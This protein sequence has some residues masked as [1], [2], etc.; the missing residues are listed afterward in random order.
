MLLVGADGSVSK[1]PPAS[2][3]AMELK[4]RQMDKIGLVLPNKKI[5]S[6]PTIL[7]KVGNLDVV[8]V[9]IPGKTIKGLSGCPFVCLKSMDIL[10]LY[11]ENIDVIGEDWHLAVPCGIN[12][13]VLNALVLLHD[14]YIAR[15]TVALFWAIKTKCSRAAPVPLSAVQ[16][17]ALP[18][19]LRNAFGGV[20]SN[21]ELSA[22]NDQLNLLQRKGSF[23]SVYHKE[24]PVPVVVGD[25]MSWRSKA[26]LLEEDAIIY[27]VFALAPPMVYRRVIL[28]TTL[29]V[30]RSDGS[31]SNIT[32]REIGHLRTRNEEEDIAVM[33]SH[34]RTGTSFPLSV[35][36]DGPLS[37]VRGIKVHGRPVAG[38]AGFP[39]TSR[40][41]T[42]LGTYTESIKRIGDVWY[43]IIPS[44]LTS[45]EKG[46]LL[47]DR[48]WE[49][50][51]THPMERAL[52]EDAAR[53]AKNLAIVD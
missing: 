37:G 42:F 5:V 1:L 18:A 9:K 14:K 30:L 6:L 8:G 27:P 28:R 33:P 45:D 7:Q 43:Y 49:L 16:T 47:A 50:I 41:G 21:S 22:F 17:W 10:G 51:Y 23:Y 3:D 4:I 35:I 24:W 32:E 13:E 31:V 38:L 26:S 12:E 48:N 29:V 40:D 53:D 39:I 11:S 20:M 2:L 15:M 34:A 36:E 44:G 46:A 52:K 19:T 25:K